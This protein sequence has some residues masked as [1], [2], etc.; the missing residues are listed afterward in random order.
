MNNM[1]PKD[2]PIYDPPE[3]WRYG[4]PKAYKPLPG[5][6]LEDTLRRDGYPEELIRQGMAKYC[7]FIGRRIE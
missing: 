4:F 2:W 6:E 5:E 3:E 1:N 7:R